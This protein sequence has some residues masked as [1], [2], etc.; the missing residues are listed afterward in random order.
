MYTLFQNLF[1]IIVFILLL[2]IA[3]VLT[4]KYII[5]TT[6]NPKFCKDQSCKRIKNNPVQDFEGYGVLMCAMQMQNYVQ[7]VTL[8]GKIAPKI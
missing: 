5:I 3:L 1:K 7:N 2:H 4:F 8:A 6:S